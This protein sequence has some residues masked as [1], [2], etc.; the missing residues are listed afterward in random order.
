MCDCY[1]HK[2]EMCGCGISMHIANNCT[3]RENVHPYCTRCTRKLKKHESH[4]I[5][6]A[7]RVFVDFVRGRG[8]EAEVEGARPGQEVI[9]LCDDEKAYGI[10]LN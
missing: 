8:R 2:C 10:S 7:V 6:N 4:K 1:I 9:I 3:A 5:T